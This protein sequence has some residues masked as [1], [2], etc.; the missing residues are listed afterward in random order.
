MS[1]TNDKTLEKVLDLVCCE[2]DCIAKQPELDQLSLNNLDTLI[3]IKKDIAEIMA[4]EKYDGYGQGSGV[5]MDIPIE[6][7]EGY[8]Y[9]YNGGYSHG[10]GYSYSPWHHNRG[11]FIEPY[12]YD[13][14]YSNRDMNMG[15]NHS[16]GRN[17]NMRMPQ[18]SR[19]GSEHE[20]IQRL[21]EMAN[22]T[23]DTNKKELIKN[24]V[25]QLEM[26]N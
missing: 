20:M 22:E 9:G 1:E 12:Y 25:S 21:N 7:P 3:D 15:M 4:M 18:Y 19:E 2:L 6:A 5:G 10:Q 13:N 24:F 23:V 16:Y 8:G 11:Y 14:G 17:M 26:M